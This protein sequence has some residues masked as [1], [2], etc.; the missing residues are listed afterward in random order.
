MKNLKSYRLFESD[1]YHK[2]QECLRTLED[3]SLELWDENFNVQVPQSL[4]SDLVR[5]QLALR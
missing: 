3:M 5:P 1:S 2:Q 4:P